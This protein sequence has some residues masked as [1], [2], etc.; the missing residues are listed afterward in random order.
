MDQPTKRNESKFKYNI[1]PDVNEVEALLTYEFTISFVFETFWD[2]TDIDYCFIIL[3]W[4]CFV[5]NE[6][7]PRKIPL[8]LFFLPYFDLALLYVVLDNWIVDISISLHINLQF[9]SH[10]LAEGPM[11]EKKGFFYEISCLLLTTW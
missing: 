2:G 9:Q 5:A 6:C 3:F 4:F 10:P 1:Y 7:Y 8:R 11:P